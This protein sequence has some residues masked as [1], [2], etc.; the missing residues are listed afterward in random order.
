MHSSFDFDAVSFRTMAL[1]HPARLYLRSCKVILGR[2]RIDVWDFV[3]C[4][5]FSSTGDADMLVRASILFPARYWGRPNHLD[6]V[7]SWV[8]D[9][10]RPTRLV[11][12]RRELGLGMLYVMQ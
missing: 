5:Y 1:F 10:G 7:F 6:L 2:Y 4:V 8:G 3:F 9:K 12:L 11:W